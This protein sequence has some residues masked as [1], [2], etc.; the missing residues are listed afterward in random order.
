MT[1][2]LSTLRATIAA[3]ALAAIACPAAPA[4]AATRGPCI[5]GQRGAPTCLIGSALA[6]RVRDGDTV[7]ARIEGAAARDVRNTGIQAVEFGECHYTEAKRRLAR[8]VHPG[9]RLRLAGRSASSY[10]QGRPRRAIYVRR[11]GRW[12]DPS[13]VLVREG[14][15]LWD[16][17]PVEDAWNADYSR[18]AQ[19]AAGRR[20]HLWNPRACGPGPRPAARLRVLAQWDAEGDDQ[21]NRNG[22]Y[23]R[24]EHRGGAGAISLRGW[25]VRDAAQRRYTF[26]FGTL[27]PGRTVTLHVGSGRHR[28]S[29]FYW[30][31]PRSIFENFDNPHS[32]ARGMGDGA[33]LFDPGGN[34][35]ASMMYPCRYACANPTRDRVR[36]TVHNRR[37]DEAVLITN[38]STV[39]V[40]L[41][42]H[43]IKTSTSR[44]YDFGALGVSS[45]VRPGETLRV[46]VG[47]SAAGDSRLDRHWEQAPPIIDDRTGVVE[48]RT[49][50]HLLTACY[51]E[52][53]ASC[54]GS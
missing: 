3:A 47:G 25:Y 29:S 30:G 37:D 21:A 19:R 14:Y 11:A 16:P 49:L 31:L 33:S 52:G 39:P 41:D 42:G 15:V 20:R 48:L 18:L 32:N 22:E 5:V 54:P 9:T 12:I 8:L 4:G 1:L 43:V 28:G 53:A 10:S 36:M 24:I 17:N 40:D 6:T 7:A 46:T 45:I 50:T 26:R 13:R 51:A 23:V 38:V 34:L 44:I 2:T 35:R 27:R